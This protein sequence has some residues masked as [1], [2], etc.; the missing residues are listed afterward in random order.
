MAAA[1]APKEK[2]QLVLRTDLMNRVHELKGRNRGSTLSGITE[3]ALDLY[4]AHLDR[5]GDAANL[6]VSA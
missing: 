2:V 5:K 1:S 4:F 6:A 3:H